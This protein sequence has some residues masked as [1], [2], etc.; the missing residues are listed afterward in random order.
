MFFMNRKVFMQRK[1][2]GSSLAVALALVCVLL[3]NVSA[4]AHT[5]MP[6]TTYN[7]NN[8]NCV[9]DQIWNGNSYGAGVQFTVDK[10]GFVSTDT[11]AYYNKY[12]LLKGPVSGERLAIGVARTKGNGFPSNADW[13]G[14]STSG[15][16]WNYFVYTYQSGGI[17][18]DHRCHPVP[19]GDEN[20]L[21][22]I[23]AITAQCEPDGL[24]DDLRV[25]FHGYASNIT[26][27]IEAELTDG[28]Y[29]SIDN[30]MQWY[31]TVQDHM[32]WGGHW[33]NSDW[34]DGNLN[35]R[36]QTRL[37]DSLYQHQPPNQYWN[38]LPSNSLPG[39]DLWS[40]VY[41]S[42]VTCTQGG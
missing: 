11:N 27:C 32:V 29:T 39:G 23:T 24:Y 40:C 17:N 42:G 7:C 9:A 41:A 2:L 30:S 4:S 13:C 34:V 25:T 19:A 37:P 31:G 22:Y 18:V 20:H 33:Y 16:I 10:P 15:V 6:A 21:T 35:L 12:M 8:A 14:G 38:T 36:G 28:Y 5:A 3:G 26:D 1:F